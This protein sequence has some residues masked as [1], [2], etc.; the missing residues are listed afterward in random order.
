MWEATDNGY[1]Q[2]RDVAAFRP[3]E[4]A[5]CGQPGATVNSDDSASRGASLCRSSGAVTYIPTARFCTP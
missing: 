4:A 5:A 2:R 3:T 1:R